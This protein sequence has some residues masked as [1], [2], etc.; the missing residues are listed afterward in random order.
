MEI[1]SHQIS[2]SLHMLQVHQDP[3]SLIVGILEIGP[4]RFLI[5]LETLHARVAGPEEEA[6]VLAVGDKEWAGHSSQLSCASA[7]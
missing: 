7:G 6:A 4:A 3:L 1:C 2:L 5:L